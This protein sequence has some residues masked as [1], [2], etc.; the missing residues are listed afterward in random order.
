MPAGGYLGLEDRLETE[1]KRRSG[2]WTEEIAS[3]SFL[4]GRQQKSSILDFSPKNK[5]VAMVATTNGYLLN[6][7]VSQANLPAKFSLL[8]GWNNHNPAINWTPDVRR[9]CCSQ[10][11]LVWRHADAMMWLPQPIRAG[12]TTM[13][14]QFIEMMWG[15]S[16]NGS[17]QLIPKGYRG[18]GMLAI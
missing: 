11:E 15:I 3:V 9:D 17:M 8:I 1:N 12:V 10:S 18:E 4:K 13:P 2:R 5:R 14:M 7:K 16:S 6:R